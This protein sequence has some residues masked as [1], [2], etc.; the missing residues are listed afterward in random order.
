MTRWHLPTSLHVSPQAPVLCSPSGCILVLD[1]KKVSNATVTSLRWALLTS[2]GFL[3]PGF[4]FNAP[5]MLHSHN[6][7]RFGIGSLTLVRGPERS[8]RH[9]NA[10][11]S[12]M[13]W[14]Q[15]TA[16]RRRGKWRSHWRK[17]SSCTAVLD[18]FV[19]DYGNRNVTFCSLS[20]DVTSAWDN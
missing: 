11:S 15:H 10:P 1:S 7:N 5:K 13:N 16:H 20:T 8:V 14:D 17:E 12:M 2:L 18:R 4:V 19:V 3:S 6:I 9:A